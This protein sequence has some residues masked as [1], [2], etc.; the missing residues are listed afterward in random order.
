MHIIRRVRRCIAGSGE[1]HTRNVPV[2]LLR[3]IGKCHPAVRIGDYEPVLRADVGEAAGV[4]LRFAVTPTA[5]QIEHKGQFAAVRGGRYEDQHGT[6]P[7]SGHN[8][9]RV[10]ASAQAARAARGGCYIE[11]QGAV[12]PQQTDQ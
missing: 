1:W 11:R 12:T 9:D 7:S 10:L 6:R 8:R 3:R 2:I 4:R 5:V